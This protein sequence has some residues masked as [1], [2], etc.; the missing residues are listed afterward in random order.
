M[1]KLLLIHPPHLNSTDDRLD[2]PLGLLQLSSYLRKNNIIEVDILDLSGE[3]KIQI[4]KIPFADFYGITV[5]ITS[6]SIT[7]E[8]IQKCKIINPSSKIIVGGAHPT[9]CPN[10][11]SYVDHVVIG[12]GEV[13]LKDIITEKEK[14]H[15]I[16]GKEPYNYF[17]FP[18]YDMINPK[19][20]NRKIADKISLPIL[21][22]RGCPYH[23]SY[24]GLEQMHKQLGYKV[25][26]AKPEIII[27]QIKTI[28]NKFGIDR[29]NFQDDIFTLNKKR[30][31]KILDNIK[32]L[33]IKF[34]CMGRA[35]VDTK[36]I[37]EKLAESGCTDIS[38]GIESGSQYILNR[39][40][41]QVS[42]QDNYNVIEWAKQAGLTSRAFF[43]L[44]FPGETQNTL[45]ETKQ[46]II[47]SDPDQY[48]CSTFVPYPGTDI[49]NNP[50]KYG[51]IN[52]ETNYDQFYQVSK[53][54]TGG[55]TTD[56]KWLTKE[57]FR[58]LEIEFRTWIKKRKMRGQLQNYEKRNGE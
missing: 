20:Y 25:K 13:A 22:S 51:V 30:L 35:G 39:M 27:S 52:I 36:E 10:D 44:G 38:W 28:K 29:I 14:N 58:K 8:I 5:Y 21:T 12:Y 11:F 31:F 4:Q 49:W 24:C 50:E 34:R 32:P 48:F 41:K 17:N 2:P 54:G 33:N 6:L 3:K 57:E 16:I 55:M 43:I 9:A 45:E 26:F 56:T 46:F 18:S 15:I 1:K 7:K 47:N 40:N 23:C 37:Y 42:V 53:D 19:S